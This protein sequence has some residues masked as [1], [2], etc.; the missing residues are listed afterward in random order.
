[1]NEEILIKL[2]LAKTDRYSVPH[3]GL[4]RPNEADLIGLSVEQL[5]RTAIQTSVLGV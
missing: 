4:F 3:C 2:K 1:M 5:R